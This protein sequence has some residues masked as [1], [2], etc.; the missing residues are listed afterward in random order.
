MI[1]YHNGIQMSERTLLYMCV[2]V[3]VFHFTVYVESQIW[4]IISM[5][6]SDKYDISLLC[7]GEGQV[8]FFHKNTS[9]IHIYISHVIF[10]QTLKPTNFTTE[11]S[12]AIAIVIGASINQLSH[13]HR[14]V[15]GKFTRESNYS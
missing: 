8:H 6:V 4:D 9:I 7:E 11:L 12:V 15:L 5:S 14:Y 3:S 2:E 10:Y 1:S 13:Q